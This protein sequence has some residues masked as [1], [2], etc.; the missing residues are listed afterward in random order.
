MKANKNGKNR[1]KSQKIQCYDQYLTLEGLTLMN[2]KSAHINCG[3]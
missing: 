1:I 3:M 2:V